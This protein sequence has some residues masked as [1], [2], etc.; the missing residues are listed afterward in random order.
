MKDR[1]RKE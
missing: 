1:C